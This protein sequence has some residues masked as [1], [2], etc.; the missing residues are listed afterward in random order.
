MD[1]INVARVIH[2][3]GSSRR[4]GVCSK[5]KWKGEGLERLP[6]QAMLEEEEVKEESG[7]DQKQREE[8]EGAC[9]G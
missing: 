9:K 2:G 5:R 4:V 8:E 6:G 3:E 1:Q 7:R